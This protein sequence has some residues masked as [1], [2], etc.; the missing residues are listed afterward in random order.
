M[1]FSLPE[2]PSTWI[3]ESVTMQQ[4]R[5]EMVEKLINTGGFPS[6]EIPEY[7]FTQEQIAA[8]EH[9]RVKESAAKKRHAE[10]D[11]GGRTSKR[12]RTGV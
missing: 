3:P 8:G 11:D 10:G 7:Y 5:D 9:L 4:K 2:I 6:A 12:A 1:P